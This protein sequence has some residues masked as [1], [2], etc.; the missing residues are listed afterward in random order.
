MAY[1]QCM[2]GR[3]CNRPPYPQTLFILRADAEHAALDFTGMLAVTDLSTCS[4]IDRLADADARLLD[5][6][7]YLLLRGAIPQSWLPPLRAA[8]E[9]GALPSEGWPVPR[10]RDWRHSLLD[11][12]P[13]VQ[14]VCRMPIMLAAAYH[15]PRPRSSWPRL[16]GANR[17]PAA[18]HNFCTGTALTRGTDC[19]SALAFLD[20]YGAH[21]GATQL[22]P[23]THRHGAGEADTASCVEGKAGDILLFDANLLHGATRNHSGAPRRSMLI[24]YG[25][26]AQRDDWDKTRQLRAVRMAHDEIYDG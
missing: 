18:A 7:G 4:R 17:L 16:R 6:Q 10:G 2:R 24:T 14:Q 12:D 26:A 8:F 5:N 21:N 1:F 19:V 11:V 13:T 15:L 25:K 9:A 22:I 20:A 23:G 3:H